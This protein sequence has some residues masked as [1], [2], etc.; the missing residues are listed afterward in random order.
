M[1]FTCCGGLGRAE[2]DELLP[3][4]DTAATSVTLEKEEG[5]HSHSLAWGGVPQEGSPL[6]FPG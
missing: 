2:V 4:T 3:V 6:S 1:V 5:G